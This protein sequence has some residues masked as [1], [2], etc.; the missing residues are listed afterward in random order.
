M[1]DKYT[2][3]LILPCKDEAQALKRLLKEIP[4]YID[5]VLIVDNGSSDNTSTVSAA[6][7]ARVIYE[8]RSNNGIGY[9]FAH[10]RGI[11]EAHGDILIS[12]DADGSY[13]L[14]SIAPLVKK[15]LTK[16]LDFISCNRIPLS[17][18][19][20]IYF[21][22]RGGI[23]FLNFLFQLL[24]KYAIKDALSGMWIFRRETGKKMMLKDGGWNFSLEIKMQAIAN[25]GI[26]FREFSIP[27]H[28][29]YFGKSKQN[30]FKTGIT[31]AAYLVQTSQLWKKLKPSQTNVV[32]AQRR[33]RRAFNSS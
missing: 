11:Q 25:P 3:S 1:V 13:P 4:S 28:D 8:P 17:V 29:R 7:G 5:E 15:L 30:L 22:R 33:F 31:H 19:S 21:L 12:M 27:Y 20:E 23:M 32:K 14:K 26:A 18:N 10:L 9:G 16:N 6:S 24:H 2:L